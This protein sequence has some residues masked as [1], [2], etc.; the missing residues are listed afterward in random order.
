MLECGEAALGICAGY[1]YSMKRKK[2]I[3]GCAFMEENCEKLWKGSLTMK[4][5][6]NICVNKKMLV[7]F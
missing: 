6:L 2:S 3:V 4:L 5:D 1:P 7:V